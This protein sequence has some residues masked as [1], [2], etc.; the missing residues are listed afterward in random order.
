MLYLLLA[1]LLLF[2]FFSVLK[3]QLGLGLLIALLP[4][5]QIRIHILTIPS[6]LLELL[7]AVFLLIVIF[8]I[9][10]PLEGEVSGHSTGQRGWVKAKDKLKSLGKI[11]YALGLFVTAGIISTV[12]SPDKTHALGQLKAYI[13]E[14]FLIFYATV[15]SIEDKRQLKIVLR[16]LL[17]SAGVIS[18]FGIFQYFT[19]VHLPLRFWGTGADIERI[20][21]VFDY[22]N[23][24]ALFLAPLFG[25]FGVLFL[26]KY[27][28]LNRTWDGLFLILL[29]IALILTFSRG[30]W[31]ALFLAFL[32]YFAQKFDWRK[33]FAA[34]VLLILVVL[35][36][37]QTRDRVALGVSDPSSLAHFDLMKAGTEKVLQSPI[38]GNGLSGFRTTLKG[39]NFQGEIL[40]YPHNIF[41]NFWLE[42]GL[43]GIISFALILFFASEQHKKQPTNLTLAAGMFLLILILHGLVD[44]P[45]FKNDLSVL[46]WFSIALFYI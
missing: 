34:A 41:L 13:I 18:L 7:I 35:A 19:L 44:V 24:L 40:N 38:L 29:A 45:Y 2:F 46:F 5:Y 23:A 33:V 4:V 28:I 1:F 8:K 42:L 3:P 37:P 31:F 9:F 21:S 22:P 14:P 17:L 10:L 6:T 11:N 26:K 30:A 15:L 12:F 25:L 43:L 32:W 39:Q 36:L 20:T 16:F 27:S